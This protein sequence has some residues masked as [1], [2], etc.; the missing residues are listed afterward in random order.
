MLEAVEKGLGGWASELLAET[1][2][3]ELTELSWS[4]TSPAN[5]IAAGSS[6]ES[7]ATSPILANSC[8]A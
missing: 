7:A 1:W 8:D 5:A 2:A 6:A 3:Y 4:E